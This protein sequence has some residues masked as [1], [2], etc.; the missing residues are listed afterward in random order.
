[1][2]VETEEDL[3][4][5]M[6]IG[7]IVG[8]T[9]QHMQNAVRPGMTTADLDAIGAE[10]M[11]QNGARSAPILTYKFPGHT[12]ISINDEAAHGIPGGR[13]IQPGDLVNID[14]SAEMD[15]YYADT[16]AS[17]QM[18]P[19]SPEKQRLCEFTQEALQAAIGVARAGQ[20]INVIGRA[21]EEVARKGG[22]SI[23]RE[24]GGHGVGKRL[25]EPPHAVPH[26][27]VRRA[28]QKLREGMVMT[29]EPFLTTG[30]IHVNTEA[31][32]WTLRTTDGSLAAQY[33]HTVI[34][35]KD[36]PILV[37]AV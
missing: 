2:T 33:E 8:L 37:T 32:G 27:F 11:L 7:R 30:A 18:P 31:D 35:T 19:F 5:L 9:L 24:L 28:N 4:G 6:R 34:I 15:G 25:H 13:V 10:F 29:L 1:M 22:Y 17:M 23:I 16:G 26:H 36:A 12:C 3:V 20:P 21:V 14:V